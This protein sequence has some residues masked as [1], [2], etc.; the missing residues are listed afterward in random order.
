MYGE[1]GFLSFFVLTVMYTVFASDASILAVH[2]NITDNA[3]AAVN[4]FFNDFIIYTKV[5]QPKSGAS[6]GFALPLH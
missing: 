6:V 3:A 2:E 1:T 4:I 5:T